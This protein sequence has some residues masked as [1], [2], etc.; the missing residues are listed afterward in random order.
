MPSRLLSGSPENRVSM[1]G[2][3]IKIDIKVD[4]NSSDFVQAMTSC[5]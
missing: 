4:T 5:V 3:Q 2:L 1:P